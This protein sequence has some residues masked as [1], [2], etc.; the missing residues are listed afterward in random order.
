MSDRAIQEAI[1]I[2]SGTNLSDKVYAVDA[3]V[4]SVD[5]VK[6]TAKVQVV[7]GKANNT[8]TARLMSAVDDGLLIIPA[9]S[10]TVGILMSDFTRPSIIQYSEV[11]RI[12]LRGGDLGGLVKI[13]EITQKLNNLVSELRA[14]LIKIQTGIIAGGGTYAPGTITRFSKADY[15]NQN[16][17]HG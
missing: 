4:I 12:I 14:E 9:I 5:E 13:V 7:S 10:S 8:I 2:L 6:R 11:D 3:T 16:I 1:Q 15:E 17:T